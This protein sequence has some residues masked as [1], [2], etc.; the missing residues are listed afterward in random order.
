MSAAMPTATPAAIATVAGN[1]VSRRAALTALAFVIFGWGLS[2]PV[3]KLILQQLSPF[4]LAAI[5]ALLATVALFAIAAVR[6]RL[7]WP[8]RRDWPVALSIA[9]LHMVGYAVLVAIGLQ[10]VPT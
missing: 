1:Q 8:H 9:L 2:W 3:H 7:A 6:G 10:W 4:W 5:R